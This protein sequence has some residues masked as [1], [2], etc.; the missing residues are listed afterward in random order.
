MIIGIDIGGTNIDI[1]SLEEDFRYIGT[2]KTSEYITKLDDLIKELGDVKAIGIGIAAWLKNGKPIHAPNLPIIPR[3][4]IDVPIVV[5][6]DANCFAY[7]ASQVF[8]IKNL[9]GI[10]VGT[11][12][13][14]GIILDGKIY[15]GSN[16]LAGEIGHIFVEGDI[17][18]KCGKKGCLEAYFGGWAL[19]NAKELLKTGKIYELKGFKLFCIALANVIMVL[20]PEAIVIGGRI[21][22]RLDLRKIRDEVL[23]Y[24]PKDFEP[25][26]YSL[27]DDLAVAKGACL[28]ART[29]IL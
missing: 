23:R 24:I 5:D 25:K 4:H 1:V 11:G 3:I 13:G 10:T 15:R 2:F 8:N 20:N 28:L 12:I 14:S 6:N 9:I 21:G 29:S 27:K 22:Y 18:C 7:Y 26:F 17:I 16:G 19:K